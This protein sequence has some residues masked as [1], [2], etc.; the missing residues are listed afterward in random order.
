[1]GANAEYDAIQ[2]ASEYTNY[3]EKA[4]VLEDFG[5]EKGACS[6]QKGDF[7][8]NAVAARISRSHSAQM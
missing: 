2:I 4:G 3:L 7:A 8:L 1:M 6:K 5:L